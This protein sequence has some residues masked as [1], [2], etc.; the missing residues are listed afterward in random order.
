MEHIKEEKGKSML[1]AKH[2]NSSHPSNSSNCRNK[3]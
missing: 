2:I 3:I 1:C